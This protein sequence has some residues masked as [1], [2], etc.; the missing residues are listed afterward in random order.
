MTIIMVVRPSC[1]GTRSVR[2]IGHRSA[3][4]YIAVAPFKADNLADLVAALHNV[5]DDD[6]ANKR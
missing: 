3:C 6:A 5:A 4:T 2:Q 1:R